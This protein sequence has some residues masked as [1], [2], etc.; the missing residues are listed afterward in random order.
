MNSKNIITKKTK[1]NIIITVVAF[2]A[3]ILFLIVASNIVLD[4]CASPCRHDKGV[5]VVCPDVC[6]EVT[7][8]DWILGN[9]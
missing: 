9:G 1:R 3:V 5:S 2:V 8:L 7:L 4:E 6:E